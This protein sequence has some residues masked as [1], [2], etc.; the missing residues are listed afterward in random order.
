MVNTSLIKSI[1]DA[2]LTASRRLSILKK[3]MSRLSRELFMQS[4]LD[5]C[6]FGGVRRIIKGAATC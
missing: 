1:S 4:I 5:A 6:L 3:G 2:G